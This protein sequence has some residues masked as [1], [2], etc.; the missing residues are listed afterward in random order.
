MHLVV[1][2]PP[3]A[4]DHDIAV[5]AA[6]RGLSV[7]PLSSCYAGRRTR[8]GLVL[9]YG[10]TRLSEIPDAVRRLASALGG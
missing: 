8:P 6:R 3:S 1:M 5:R 10:A 2:L 9:G 7:L 4:R